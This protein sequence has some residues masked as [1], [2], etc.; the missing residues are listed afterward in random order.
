L[1]R[2]QLF[3]RIPVFRDALQ[4]IYETLRAFLFEYRKIEERARR[5]NTMWLHLRRNADYEPRAWDEAV[6]LPAWLQRAP[7]MPVITHA[8]LEHEA[9]SEALTSLAQSLPAAAERRTR[10]RVV[11][12]LKNDSDTVP[13]VKLVPRPHVAALRRLFKQARAA[14]Q[15]ISAR[16]WAHHFAGPQF[17]LTDALWLEVVLDALVKGGGGTRGVS[18]ETVD[19]P[20]EHLTFAKGN[21]VVHDIKVGAWKNV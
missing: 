18:Y 5:L 12:A 14:E 7:R 13:V 8:D 4:R 3:D 17:D 11:G 1:F 6:D 20:V 19:A 9:S 16:A 10:Q 15:P 21:V 2:L